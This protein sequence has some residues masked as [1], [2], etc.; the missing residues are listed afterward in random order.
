[1]KKGKAGV[2]TGFL[3]RMR[4]RR[5]FL[6]NYETARAVRAMRTRSGLSVREGEGRARGAGGGSEKG[7]AEK[8]ETGRAFL[9]AFLNK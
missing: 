2:S 7:E 3:K 5:R 6:T 1:M 9:Y 8:Q 4:K